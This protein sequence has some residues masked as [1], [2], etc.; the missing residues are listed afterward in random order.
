MS[1]RLLVFDVSGAHALFKVPGSTRSVVT[2]PFP[3]RTAILGMV[4]AMLGLPRN[5]Y[6]AQGHPLRSATVAVEVTR[7]GMLAAYADRRDRP[8]GNPTGYLSDSTRPASVDT[9][10]QFAA[11]TAVS[12]SVLVNPAFRVYFSTP[13]ERMRQA[14]ERALR[15]RMYHYSPYFGHAS[16]PAEVSLVGSFRCDKMESGEYE[17]R[18]VVPIQPEPRTQIVGDYVSIMGV[19]MSFHVEEVEV[20]GERQYVPKHADCMSAVAY[21]CPHRKSNVRVITRADSITSVLSVLHHS[22]GKATD[23]KRPH[24]DIYVTPLPSGER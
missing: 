5:S 20:D 12:S 18:T 22:D 7:P 4:G 24:G 11:T 19:P 2:F 10:G 13:D 17:V 9:T 3:P 6:W 1:A 15:L 21:H 8:E 23:M 16:M 14:L